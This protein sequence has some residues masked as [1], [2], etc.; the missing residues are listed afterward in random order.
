M[1]THLII[2]VLH[3]TMILRKGIEV[4]VGYRDPSSYRLE[5]WNVESAVL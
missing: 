2:S 1:C 3:Y 5:M 4:K